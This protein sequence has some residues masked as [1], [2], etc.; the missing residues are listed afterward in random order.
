MKRGVAVLLAWICLA[1]GMPACAEDSAPLILEAKIPLGNVRGRIDH[2]AI[3]LGRR[4]LYVAELGNDSVGV[5]DL[6]S[7]R[8]IQTIWG[9]KEPQGVG[10]AAS[11]DTLYV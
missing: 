10:Y 9:L 2:F 1:H 4:R 3:D 5:L 11:S 8:V 7:G 6:N